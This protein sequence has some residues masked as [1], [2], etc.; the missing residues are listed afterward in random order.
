MSLRL[1]EV[2][3]ILD[4][5]KAELLSCLDLPMSLEI[6][7]DIK[8]F[9]GELLQVSRI[10]PL[11]EILHWWHSCIPGPELQEQSYTK[12]LDAAI[13]KV[14]LT[15]SLPAKLPRFCYICGVGPTSPWGQVRL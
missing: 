13:H 5:F 12:D 15:S 3:W 6:Y 1:V 2:N 7:W 4:H 11:L 10:V 14:G 8:G 9:F